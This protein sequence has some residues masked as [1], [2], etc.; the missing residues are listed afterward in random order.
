MYQ[1]RQFRQSPRGPGA[2]NNDSHRGGGNCNLLFTNN[3]NRI[4]TRA[5]HAVNSSGSVRGNSRIHRFYTITNSYNLCSRSETSTT[6]TTFDL[7]TYGF[8]IHP[9]LAGDGTGRRVYLV[10]VRPNI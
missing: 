9:R 5:A 4:I 6:S 7:V 3:N 1:R 8:N 10:A 2:H